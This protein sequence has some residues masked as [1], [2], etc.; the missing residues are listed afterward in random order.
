MNIVISCYTLDLSGTPTYT[1]TLCDEL[2]VRG[3]DVTVYSPI[4][5][6]LAEGLKVKTS[7]SEIEKPDVIIAQH[8]SCAIDL[9]NRFP[10]VPM[11]FSSHGVGP[12]LEQP[13]NIDIQ[14]YI[15]VNEDVVENLVSKGVT[16]DKITIV[17]DFINIDR[18]FPSVNLNENPKRMLFISNYRRSEA[19]LNTKDACEKLGIEF[20]AAGAPY[21]R[22]YKIEKEILQSDIVVSIARGILEAMSCGRVAISYDLG[23]GDGYID[24]SNYFE[25][26]TRNFGYSKC[27][28]KFTVDSL[29]SEIKKYDLSS[30]LVNRNFIVEHHNHRKAVD[31]IEEIINK[32]L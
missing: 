16:S 8:N 23:M 27:K 30:S 4:S 25:S 15:A 32:R 1:V 28:Y 19:F 29:I 21:R 3:H 18:F 9:K 10:K 14:W 5:G 12:A 31:K 6:K 7:V 17:R 2:K 26:R 20:K 11:I 22:A 24:S 13:P